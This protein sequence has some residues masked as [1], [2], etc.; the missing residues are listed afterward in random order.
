MKSIEDIHNEINDLQKHLIYALETIQEHQQLL[1]IMG[2]LVI[3]NNRLRGLIPQLE[4]L[5]ARITVLEN[6]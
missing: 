3:D 1:I 5:E 6:R 4:D 2:A